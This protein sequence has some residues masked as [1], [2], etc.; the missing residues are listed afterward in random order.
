MFRCLKALGAGLLVLSAGSLYAQ[1]IDTTS[2]SAVTNAYNNTYVPAYS[3]PSGWNGNV[4]VCTAGTT[5]TAYQQAVIN[6]ANFYRELAGLPTVNLVTDAAA[7]N[8]ARQAALYMVANQTITHTPTTGLCYTA[9]A[10]EG[11]GSS[12]LAV[13][14]SSAAGG[15]ISLA[16]GPAAIDGYVDDPGNVSTLG[17]RR[18]VLYTRQTGLATGD[19]PSPVDTYAANALRV[20]AAGEEASTLFWS[21]SAPAPR[22]VA[23]PSPN[24]VP[25]KLLPTQSGQW[26]ISYPG[27]NFS[28]ATVTISK[29]DGSAVTATDVAPLPSGYG[30]N[31][32]SFIPDIDAAGAGMADASYKVQIAGVTG[33][34]V[35]TSYCYTVTVF[36]PNNS[37]GSATAPDL[38]TTP[39]AQTPAITVEPAV[40]ASYVQSAPAAALSI[41]ANVS[42][43]GT[44]SY[45]WYSN[46]TDSTSGG[47]AI[48]GA[49]A[50][51]YTPSTAATGT[52]YYYVVV[53]NTKGGQTASATSGTAAITVTTAAPIFGIALNQTGTY[54]FAQAAAGYAAL[55]ALTVRVT[56]TGNQPTGAL[57][58]A[59]SSVNFTVTGAS[60]GSIAVGGTATFTLTPSTGLAAG[61]YTTTVTVSGGSVASQTFGASFT[62]TPAPAY[63]IALTNPGGFVALGGVG[64]GAFTPTTVQV[65]NTGNQPTGALTVGLSG[66]NASSF[67]ISGS[68]IPSAGIAVGASAAFGV[69][70]KTGLAAGA[71][72]AT[73]TV[74]G[75]NGI[76]ASVNLSFLVS[77]TAPVIT[78]TAL[79]SSVVNPAT[80]Y[81]VTLV[82]NDPTAT[83]SS[84][85]TLPDGL[86]LSTAGVISGVPTVAGTFTFSVIAT[87]VTGDSAPVTFSITILAPTPPAP[88]SSGAQGIPALSPAALALLGLMLGAV[89]ALRQRRRRQ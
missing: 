41:T 16:T 50:S 7:V 43:G 58:V 2:R 79:P 63:G 83:W 66:A 20:Y 38:C 64:Y 77:A 4:A 82:S 62:V 29:S 9:A 18:W 60:I 13:G 75:G 40:S 53:T 49:N 73:L 54:T 45:Q 28:A 88:V 85:G 80:P 86:T 46:T 11:A 26:S 47:A 39:P 21:S 57:T 56:N 42:D 37:A 31:T 71:Y 17:H 12:N 51:T 25:Y 24:F 19:I 48:S 14:F 22:W 65:T 32:L 6:V 69:A 52:T 27:A 44:L 84:T 74:S 70:P 78:S 1:T 33:A 87:N 30:D 10:S 59:S 89:A 5:S 76:T 35:P 68:T 3:V 36:D 8:R 23:W 15:A 81:S 34:G 55:P 67:T 72:S 61:P